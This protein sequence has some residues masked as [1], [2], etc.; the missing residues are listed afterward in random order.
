ML[1]AFVGYK[2]LVST[3]LQRSCNERVSSAGSRIDRVD[4]ATVVLKEDAKPRYSFCQTYED[5][6][7]I[8]SAAPAFRATPAAARR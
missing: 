7:T 2:I 6:Q 4:L 5:I 1:L 8:R 3:V